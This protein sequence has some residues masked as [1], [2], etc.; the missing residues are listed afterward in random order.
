MKKRKTETVKYMHESSQ[1]DIQWHMHKPFP[2]TMLSS[3]MIGGKIAMAYIL[4]A[5]ESP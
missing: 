3:S 4:V 1:D 5:R 2:Y